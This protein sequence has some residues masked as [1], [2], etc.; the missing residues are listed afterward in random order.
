VGRF[1]PERSNHRVRI[2]EN[3]NRAG[4]SSGAINKVGF[5]RSNLKDD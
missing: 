2:L 3:K 1:H 4:I 5:A